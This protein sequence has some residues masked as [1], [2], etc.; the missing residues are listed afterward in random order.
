[1]IYLIRI[2][3]LDAASAGDTG[4]NVTV[5][6]AKR[7]E[8]GRTTRDYVLQDLITVD[9]PRPGRLRL[10]HPGMRRQRKGHGSGPGPRAER[11]IG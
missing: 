7:P 1:M 11:R 3:F 9:G 5:L 8:D 4:V 10:L 6:D 2:L